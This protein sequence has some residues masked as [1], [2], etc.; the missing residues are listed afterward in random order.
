MKGIRNTIGISALFMSQIP[1][2]VNAQG[3][4]PL[5]SLT[6]VGQ[7]VYG[8]ATPPDIKVT[9]G[10]VVQILLGFIG[11]LF[12][13]LIIVGGFRWMTSGGNE[14]KID[15]AKRLITN[16]TIGLVVI[17]LAYSIAFSV[18]KWLSIATSGDSSGVPGSGSP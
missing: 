14:Q 4:D 3:V 2:L 16:A 12:V 9:I 17:V 7:Q 6:N 5:K 1:A 18:T 11:I 8:N 13:V 10:K 15:E